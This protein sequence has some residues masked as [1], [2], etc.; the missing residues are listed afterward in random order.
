[1]A[2]LAIGFTWERVARRSEAKQVSRIGHS[3]DIGGRS[4][5]IDCAGEGG[6]VVILDSGFGT[7]GYVWLPI[8][9]RIATFAQV[10]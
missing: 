6:P 5:N 8:Q 9:S 2:A 4:M 3:V 1:M 7:P 10:C